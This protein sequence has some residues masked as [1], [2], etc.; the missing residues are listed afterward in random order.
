MTDLDSTELIMNALL[1]ELLKTVEW[2]EQ[3]P[4]CRLPAAAAM[5]EQS[6][7][8]LYSI[9][10]RFLFGARFEEAGSGGARKTAQVDQGTLPRRGESVGADEAAASAPLAA[11]R[12]SSRQGHDLSVGA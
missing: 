3:P 9:D 5:G 8:S 2:P 10:L 6:Q 11:I 1:S 4:A 12:R 7:G